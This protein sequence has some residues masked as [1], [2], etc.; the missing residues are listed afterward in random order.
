MYVDASMLSLPSRFAKSKKVEHEQ[1]ILETFCKVKVNIPLLDVIKQVP[2]YTKFLNNLCTTKCKLKGNEI[3]SLGENVST[4]LQ[5]KLP[6][7]RKDPNYFTIPCII[8]TTRFERVILD[9]EATINVMPY[10]IYALLNIVLSRTMF[11]L[12]S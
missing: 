7:K 1:R 2:R 12:Y 8:R 3:V 11:L 9:L 6:P 10:S 5:R 4:V